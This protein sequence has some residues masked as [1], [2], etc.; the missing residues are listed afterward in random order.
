MD[1]RQRERE[2]E[3]TNKEQ[4][5]NEKKAREKK[6]I[7]KKWMRSTN[8][9][10]QLE[11]VFCYAFCSFSSFIIPAN[12]WQRGWKVYIPDSCDVIMNL[13]AHQN[14]YFIDFIS[15]L[16][17]LFPLSHS[18]S[19]LLIFFFFAAV[20]FVVVCSFIYYWI[21]IVFGCLDHGPYPFQCLFHAAPA[22]I[23]MLYPINTI[24]YNK[25]NQC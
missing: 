6:E 9:N 19:M 16:S 10:E 21:G 12:V 24:Q 23:S 1:E 15:S 5:K 18:L 13:F 22:N 4:S 8:K 14:Q 17:L 25:T 11:K 7:I 2:R 3:R 20:I